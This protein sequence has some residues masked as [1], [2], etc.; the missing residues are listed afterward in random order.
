MKHARP[1]P[2]IAVVV[3][4][5]AAT[6]LAG[7]GLAGDAASGE[8]TGPG[9]PSA[10]AP[11][12]AELEASWTWTPPPAT[13]PGMPAADGNDVALTV[14][15]MR[16]VMLG[17][18]GAV[19][20][21]AYRQGLRS[22]APAFSDDLVLAATEDGLS[23]FDRRSGRP[24]W[25][26]RLGERTNAPAV[27]DGTAIV[28]T[29]DGSMAGIDLRDGRIRWR[30]TLGGNSL[31]PPAGAGKVATAT[32]AT[33]TVA[34]AVAVDAATGRQRWKVPLP[35]GGTSAPAIVD[36]AGAG[37]L[38]VMVAGDI[39]AHALSLEDGSERWRREL[40]G[41]GSPEVPPLALP[42][43][44]V[45]VAHRLGGMAM[46]DARDGTQEWAAQSD[47]AA[48]TGGPAGPG[49]N[50]WFA[51]PLYDGSLMLAKAGSTEFRDPDGRVTGVA[52]GPDN[53]LLVGTGQGSDAGLLAA[54]GW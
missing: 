52:R 13:S 28:T 6:S 24:R 44:K 41:A 9:G 15:R 33:Q 2:F 31:G 50:G 7:C 37:K 38:V 47:A 42:G 5:F 8:A 23:A 27:V 40:G 35:T 43:A 20:W 36:A 29:W 1:K 54:S 11:E 18:T 3:A 26:A 16:L 39:A 34:G 32:F 4:V 48:V 53:T 49:P 25:E 21:E 14:G 22:V 45:L 19:Q 12:L 17:R 10:P 46:L 30:A 51:M